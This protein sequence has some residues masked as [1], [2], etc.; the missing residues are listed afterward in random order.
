VIIV[1]PGWSGYGLQLLSEAGL[2]CSIEAGGDFDRPKEEDRTQYEAVESFRKR[3]A[4]DSNFV[5]FGVFDAA[6]GGW[7][8]EGETFI[9]KKLTLN[10]TWFRSKE[11]SVDALITWEESPTDYGQMFSKEVRDGWLGYAGWPSATK[12]SSPITTKWITYW[13]HL[14][15]K[16]FTTNGYGLF[17]ST[18][19]RLPNF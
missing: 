11:W 14:A 13:A 12:M 7:D 17:P 8:I 16:G 10:S 2:T 5:L 4:G 6:I 19:T 15:R 1:A 9:R 3:E 18:Q